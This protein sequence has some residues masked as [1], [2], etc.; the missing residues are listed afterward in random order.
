MSIK[1]LTKNFF[2]KFDY[3]GVH[4]KFHYKLKEE[5][6]SAT[7][8][9]I[10]LSFILTAFVYVVINFIPF[11]QRKN[12][13]II[14]YT[15]EIPRTDEIS[16]QNFSSNVA[17]GVSCKNL[18]KKTDIYEMLSLEIN[19]VSIKK[20][21]DGVSEKIKKDV[22][23][24]FCDYSSFY[25]NFNES[26]DDFGLNYY[27]CPKN[28]SFSI[29]GIFGDPNFEYYELTF[30]AKDKANEKLMKTLLRDECLLGIYIVDVGIDIY[31]FHN[32]IKRFLRSKLFA[33][34]PESLT[35]MNLFFK[36]NSFSSYDNLFFSNKKTE[37]YVDFSGSEEY[38]IY[39]GLDR[40][41]EVP[42]DFDIFAKIYLRA[43][44][45]RGI[46]QRN[47]LKFNEFTA[48]ISSIL[49]EIFI[50][51][52]LFTRHI[53]SFYANKSAMKK[54]F[55]FREDFNNYHSKMKTDLQNIVIE[56]NTFSRGNK[57]IQSDSDIPM[58]NDGCK[59]KK[60]NE[61][62]ISNYEEPKQK[63]IKDNNFIDGLQRASNF[64]TNKRKVSQ[65][66]LFYYNIIE[67]LFIFFV[68]CFKW[69]TLKKK[70]TYMKNCQLIFR[71]Q[72]D[73]L[74]YIKHLQLIDILGYILLGQNEYKVFNFLANPE[75]SLAN[76]VGYFK[77]ADTQCINPNDIAEF[78]SS[79]QNLINKPG[80]TTLESKLCKI[81]NN[82]LKRFLDCNS[83]KIKN[84]IVNNT[85]ISF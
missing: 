83:S 17:V 85:T 56:T 38:S 24:D 50:C 76:K 32:P 30:R 59:L 73:I 71:S 58:I 53:N 19:F 67:T 47:Y 21:D 6:Y 23:S 8:G 69:K 3:F 64:S 16:L 55:Q 43:N 14:S 22:Q 57:K 74:N 45:K 46:I 18:E 33:V 82:Q 29:K 31:N 75:I 13:S 36:L 11:V 68:P 70:K 15:T 78:Y 79:F 26:F 5:Y 61:N 66:P 10:F 63:Q 62:K 35:K 41:N 37:Y 9:V 1:V 7:G 60:L 65:Y 72:L 80:K 20:N 51:L 42:E 84:N 34:R 49:S 12:F 27:Y 2:R 25:N 81:T 48:N 77:Q 39:K 4:F 54:I 28:I 52:F 40:F 44:D